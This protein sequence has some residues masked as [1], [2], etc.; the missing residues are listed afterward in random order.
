MR[1][2]APSFDQKPADRQQHGGRAVECR[3]EGGQIGDR[4]RMSVWAKARV[5]DHVR[6]NAIRIHS[7][8]RYVIDVRNN[9]FALPRDRLSAN[10]IA[11]TRNATP[12]SSAPTLYSAPVIRNAAGSIVTGTSVAAHTAA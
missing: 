2:D 5:A 6:A 10:R 11:V 9:S 3:V 8:G 12:S 1:R 7:S 4:H